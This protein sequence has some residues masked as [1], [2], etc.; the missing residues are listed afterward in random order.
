MGWYATYKAL[1]DGRGPYGSVKEALHGESDPSRTLSVAL[2]KIKDEINAGIL[3]PDRNAKI[4]IAYW[5][6][7]FGKQ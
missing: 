5:K 6:R 3:A 2:G 7:R 4:R 1:V